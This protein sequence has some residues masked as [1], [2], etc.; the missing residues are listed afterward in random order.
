MNVKQDSL[1][2]RKLGCEENWS[3]L[4]TDTHTHTHTHT[5]T[6]ENIIMKPNT[7]WKSGELG[8]C[9]GNIMEGVNFLTCSINT[10]QIYGIIAMIPIHIMKACS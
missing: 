7:V 6:Q 8:S 4:H 5:H 2:E 1:W 10:S 3:V 9:H